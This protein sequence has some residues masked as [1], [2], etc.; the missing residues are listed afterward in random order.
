MS[1]R[2]GAALSMPFYRFRIRAIIGWHRTG[3]AGECTM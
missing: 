2:A 1:I 3:C